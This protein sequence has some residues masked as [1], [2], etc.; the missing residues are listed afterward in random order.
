MNFYAI[1]RPIVILLLQDSLSS[2]VTISLSPLPLHNEHIMCQPASQPATL[3]PF[4]EPSHRITQVETSQV[5]DKA[6]YFL[7][8]PRFPL[9]NPRNANQEY[10]PLRP[11]APGMGG[12]Q[13]NNIKILWSRTIY[14]ADPPP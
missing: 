7:T 3:L 8:N 6:Q 5:R 4:Q 1:R 12:P 2:K 11:T 10:H 13:R 9:S 14:P